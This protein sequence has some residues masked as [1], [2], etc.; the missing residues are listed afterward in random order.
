MERERAE[1]LAA[2]A[3]PW[4]TAEEAHQVIEEFLG[5]FVLCSACG[6]SGTVTY[7]RDTE[8]APDKEPSDGLVRD[9]VTLKAGTIRPC[10]TCG[11]SESTEGIKSCD[12]DLFAWHCG[13]DRPIEECQEKKRGGWGSATA[14]GDPVKA[15]EKYHF[16]VWN[17][18]SSGT[19]DCLR[20]I[21]AVSKSYTIIGGTS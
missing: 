6:G 1:R 16:L 21:E 20:R 2:L 10:P 11:G 7:R 8:I 3:V 13:W 12:P 15:H 14:E 9:K 19:K 4:V 17:P 18:T 5:Q